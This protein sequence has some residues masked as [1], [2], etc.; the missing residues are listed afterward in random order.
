L[1]E[2][3]G[4]DVKYG[5]HALRLGYQGYEIAKHGTLTLPMKDNERADCIAVKRG[6]VDQSIV[7]YWCEE[8]LRN[9]EALLK[10]GQTP[11]PENANLDLITEVA[12]EMQTDF[13]GWQVERG[14]DRG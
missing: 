11:L 3:Y 7:L 2:K 1:I 14:F 5:S 6:E 9:T 4:W 12:V 8:L 10:G 13:W